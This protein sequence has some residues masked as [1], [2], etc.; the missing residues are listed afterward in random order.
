MMRV[1]SRDKR[2]DKAR[3]EEDHTSDRSSSVVLGYVGGRV[4]SETD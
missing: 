3:V 1:S 4:I 2:E